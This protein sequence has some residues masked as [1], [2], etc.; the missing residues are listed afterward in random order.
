MALRD[1]P[2]I[3]LY[4]QDF[5]TDEKLNE[6]SA[7]SV[8]VYIMLMCV[9]HKSKDYGTILLR[10][11][12]RQS[13]RQISN[14][15]AKLTKHLPYDVATI[16]RALTELLDEGVLNID[17]DMLYQKRMVGDGKLSETRSAAGKKGAN[18]T[19]NRFF[20]AANRAAKASANS[21]Y[22]IESESENEIEY[23]NDI[24]KDTTTCV[25]ANIQEERFAEFWG[26][27]PKKASK[28][29]ALK[30]WKKLQPDAELHKKIMQA[31][32]AQKQSKQWH[33]DNGQYIP[34]PATWLNGGQWDNELEE[35]TTGS[36]G[37]V[38][39]DMELLRKA[40]KRVGL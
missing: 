15:A 3:P 28:Q 32:N 36:A 21:E 1:Q 35:A 5:L 27:Y 40:Q 20:A 38:D 30:A 18:T 19:N 37:S 39:K 10:Q 29:Y 33:R 22:E 12:D 2:Y 23:E 26:A 8:G 4:V 9:M 25:K 34:Y 24:E 16:E 6:C 14:F 17:G 31:V 13:D 11:K 7:E